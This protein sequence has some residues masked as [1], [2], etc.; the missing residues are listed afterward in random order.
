MDLSIN[1]IPISGLLTVNA[2]NMHSSYSYYT[3][4]LMVL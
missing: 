4:T 1:N 2:A 3:E